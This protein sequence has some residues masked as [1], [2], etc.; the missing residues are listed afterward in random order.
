MELNFSRRGITKDWSVTA[1]GTKGPVQVRHSSG[2]ASRHF[3]YTP[4]GEMK[5]DFEQY[6]AAYGPVVHEEPVEEVVDL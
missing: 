3:S 2:V 1:W 6:E 5:M 4:N